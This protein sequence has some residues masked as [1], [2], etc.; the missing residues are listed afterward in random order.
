MNKIY[1]INNKINNEIILKF[2]DNTFEYNSII[3]KFNFIQNN[4]LLIYWD[5]FLSEIF[6]TEDSY[7]YFS[8]LDLKN[9]FTKIFLIHNEWND[10]AIINFKEMTIK[11]IE[12]NNESGNIE[13]EDNYLSIEWNNWGKEKYIKVD[14][15]TYVQE[16]YI[17]QE[18]HNNIDKPIYIFIHI[19]M[20]NDWKTIFLDQINTIKKSGLYDIVEKINLGIIGDINNLKDDIFIDNKFNILY[21]DS[22]VN[23]YEIHTINFIKSFCD[24]IDD[25]AY[26]LYIHTKGIRNAGNEEV[27]LS[28]RK[29][30]EYF[31]IEKYVEC[32]KYMNYFDT[33][34][35]NVINK[36]CYNKDEVSI[37]KNHT[38]HYSGNFWW[39]K[40]TYID[41]LNYLELDYTKE[42]INT[43]YR[44]ENWILSNYPETKIGILFQDI[45]NTHPYHRYVFDYYKNMKIIIK[46]I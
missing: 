1:I 26:I 20:L 34:G 29:M 42:S 3:Y 11:R 5:T 43:R 9:I 44:A 37:N 38:Y 15:Y 13:I 27:T 40:K 46:K 14:N 8:N 45:T 32:L 25:E 12:F 31:L 36:Y 28:W 18:E 35:N 17:Y 41:K 33:I 7:I 39:S 24:N 30:M 19:C 4:Q 6:Y 10:Q 16:D 22:R 21:I 2:E 23:L